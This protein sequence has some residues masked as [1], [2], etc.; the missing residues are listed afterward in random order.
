MQPPFPG[1]TTTV[2]DVPGYQND[3]VEDQGKFDTSVTE[4]EKTSTSSKENLSLSGGAGKGEGEGA[5]KE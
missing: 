2:V 5:K 1:K 4:K 3:M